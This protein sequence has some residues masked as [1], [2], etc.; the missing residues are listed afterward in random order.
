MEIACSNLS[1]CRYKTIS[2]TFSI[3][4]LKNVV[5][6]GCVFYYFLEPIK[7]WS[8]KH[9]DSVAPKILSGPPPS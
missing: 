2:V 4:A 8:E 7:T 3:R 6:C 1:I 9:A 5:R